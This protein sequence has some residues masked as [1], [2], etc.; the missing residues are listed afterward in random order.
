MYIYISYIY[1]YIYI[2]IYIRI[3]YI[4]DSN[5]I[6]KNGHECGNGSNSRISQCNNISCQSFLI[7]NPLLRFFVL[8]EK[9]HT[10]VD[11]IILLFLSIVTLQM[12]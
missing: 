11:S 7:S 3:T 2:H 8:L 6:Q 9:E 10:T 4:N 5:E 1:I 12:L